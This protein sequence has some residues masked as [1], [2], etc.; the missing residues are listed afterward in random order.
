M[1]QG[2]GLAQASATER[3]P[4]KA[5]NNA[6]KS[7]VEPFMGDPVLYK[8]DR[9]LITLDRSQKTKFYGTGPKKLNLMGLVPKSQQLKQ[10]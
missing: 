6:P 3:W 7:T 9:S 4:Y 2:L 1:L 10:N 8:R 5:E